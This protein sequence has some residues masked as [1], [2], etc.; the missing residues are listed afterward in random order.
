[1]RKNMLNNKDDIEKPSFFKYAIL[2]AIVFCICVISIGLIIANSNNK[3]TGLDILSEMQEKKEKTQEVAVSDV[4]ENDNS[5]LEENYNEREIAESSEDYKQIEELE[6]TMEEV[7][8]EFDD[9]DVEAEVKQIRTWYYS[10]TESD[11]KF[12][13]SKGTDDWNY[14]REYYFHDGLLYFV[15]I[16]NGSEEH[17]LYFKDNV[18]IRY[19]DENKNVYDYGNTSDFYDWE[20]RA[21]SEAKQFYE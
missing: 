18:M 20:D 17:R 1:M 19:I 13:I 21:L 10:P 12:V 3:K 6:N 7:G 11:E 15:F 9:L 16:F 4:E 5:L 14:S 8:V 2:I